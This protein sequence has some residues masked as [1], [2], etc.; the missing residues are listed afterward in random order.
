MTGTLHQNGARN[1]I[2]AINAAPE[3][4]RVDQALQGMRPH[5]AGAVIAAGVTANPATVVPG[6]M[7]GIHVLADW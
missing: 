7:P 6:F 5:A 3:Q 1:K 4:S 2:N